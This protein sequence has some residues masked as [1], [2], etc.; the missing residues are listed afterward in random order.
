MHRQTQ[1]LAAVV[2]SAAL[3]ACGGATAPSAPGA[4]A[5]AASGGAANGGATASEPVASSAAPSQAAAGGGAF[6]GHLTDAETAQDLLSL[7]PAELCGKT[8]GRYA[9]SGDEWFQDADPAAR[10]AL[11]AAGKTVGDVIAAVAI[12][13][14]GSVCNATLVRMKGLAPD[15]VRSIAEKNGGMAGATQ[16]TVDGRQVWHR[17]SELQVIYYFLVG[18][19][20]VM[21]SALD[22]AAARQVLAA[23]PTQ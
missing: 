21:A 12:T 20:L 6:T 11:A 15:Q 10:D 22:D 16:T 8:P 9:V 3:A 7:I 17:A 13:Q 14:G 2:L 23:L 5:G 19:V 1:G 18:D 4:G